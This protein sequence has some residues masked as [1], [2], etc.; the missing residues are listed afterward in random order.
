MELEV[1]V[2][3]H[4]LAAEFRISRSSRTATDVVVVTLHQD[5]L[6]GRGECA[7]NRRYDETPET[8]L[9]ELKAC[10]MD[11]LTAN[12]AGRARLQGCLHAG[13]ARNGL[14]CA[15]WDLEAKLTGVPAATRAA[16]QVPATFRTAL[17][18]SIDTPDRM[19]DAADKLGPGQLIKVKLDSEL[20]VERV[21]A[22]ADAVLGARMI[23]DAN[24]AWSVDLLWAVHGRLADLGVVAI[25]QPL[26]AGADDGL[27]G[28]G[29]RVPIIADEAC[30]VGADVASLADRYHGVNVKLD[31]SGGL[32][33][34][35]AVAK[36]A[37]DHGLTLMVG[38]MLGTSLAMAPAS[39][40]A[41][42]AALV[43]LDAPF[44]LKTDRAPSMAVS[45]GVLAA[46]LPELWG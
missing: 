25:E 37:R 40:L 30:H 31:K 44:L 19:A 35:L 43:D 14:D 3:R 26:P 6:I 32:T 18:L 15:L 10:Q 4:E 13:S 38:C 46:P 17:T 9:A 27:R 42:H 34:A 12:S 33:E 16:V 8:T 1:A 28:L 36:A 7:P 39:L 41:A 23:V 11:G 22:I 45:P 2:E 21:R 29:S 5:G 20:V 24:E